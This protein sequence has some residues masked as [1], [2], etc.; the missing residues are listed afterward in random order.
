MSSIGISE[1]PTEL[2]GFADRGHSLTIDH[3]WHEVADSVLSWLK[4][5][6]L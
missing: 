4:G 6:R 5:K 1:A 3:G 2:T